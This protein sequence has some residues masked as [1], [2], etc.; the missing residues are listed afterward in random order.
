MFVLQCRE[1]SRSRGVKHS[2]EDSASTLRRS[3]SWLRNW[4]RTRREI[5]RLYGL[6]GLE[7]RGRSRGR[8]YGRV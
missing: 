7:V 3:R 8:V 5:D 2:G 4:L 1:T 6:T